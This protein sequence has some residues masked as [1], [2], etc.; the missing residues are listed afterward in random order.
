MLFLDDKDKLREIIFI[1]L[2]RA[3][4]NVCQIVA[5]PTSDN[6]TVVKLKSGVNCFHHKGLGS[7]SGQSMWV[8][9]GHN[10]NG[11]GFALSPAVSPCQGHSTI[12]SRSFT[13]LTLTLYN[14]RS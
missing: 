10:G 13:H 1:Y 8:C 5:A 7:I 6:M 4:C 12:A 14:L 11:I 9:G 3:D 2:I